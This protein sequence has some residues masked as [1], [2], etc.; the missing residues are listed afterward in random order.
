VNQPRRRAQHLIAEVGRQDGD[1]VALAEV[2]SLAI[3]VDPGLL[4]AAR[5]S[6]VPARGPDLEADLWHSVLVVSANPTGMVLDDD[7]AGELRIRLARRRLRYK[8]ARALVQAEHAWLPDTLKLEEQ[9]RY[10]ALVP[11]GAAT[12]RELL[13]SLGERLEVPGGRGLSDWV[14]GLHHRLP[15]PLAGQLGLGVTLPRLGHAPAAPSG[16]PSSIAVRFLDG[17]VEFRPPPAGTP[18]IGL[19]CRPGLPLWSTSMTSWWTSRNCHSASPWAIAG[20]SW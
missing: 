13:T 1:I 17:A 3:T 18:C 16:E 8:E 14:E 6:F 19:T 7:V 10:L 20:R 2:L 5:R 11:G 9:L 12:A 4:R 15:G